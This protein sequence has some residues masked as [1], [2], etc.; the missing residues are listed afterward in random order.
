MLKEERQQY[1]LKKIQANQKVL[2]VELSQ[3]LNVSDDTIRR[4]LQE[5]EDNGFLK[6]VHGGA[7]PKPK[8]PYNIDKRLQ[9]AETERQTIARKTIPFF[10]DK[11]VIVMDN[12]STNL[13]IAQLLPHHLS[14]T[15]ITNSLPIAHELTTHPNLQLI[16]LGGKI[17]K[18]AQ[19]AVGSEVIRGLSHIRA[20]WCLLGVC[21]IH[22]EV[23]VTSHDWE[24]CQAK[25]QMT[26]VS[27]QVIATSTRYKINTAENFVVCE[28]DKLDMLI[29]DD[30]IP[31]EI[32]QDYNNK[33]VKIF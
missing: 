27:Q 16:F 4:D 33:G 8:L 17:F 23:G 9:L 19:A 22:H 15:V 32:L 1:I 25:R 2:S 18:D 11:Q 6:K 26:E 10:E 12:G 7:I 30:T 3:E 29:T 31:V 28:Y 13:V 14:I 21:S 20:D 5:L 24:E